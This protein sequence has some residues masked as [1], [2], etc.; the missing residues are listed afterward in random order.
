MTV[1]RPA[2]K[3]GFTLIEL[4]VV[5][6]IIAVLIGLLLPA[7]QRVRAVAQLT[8]CQNNLHQLGLACQSYHDANQTLPINGSVSFYTLILDYVEEGAQ[9]A[10]LASGGAPTQVNTFLCP[11]KGRNGPLCDYV[12]FAPYTADNYSSSGTG[13]V[14]SGQTIKAT[15]Q[16]T[17]SFYASYIGGTYPLYT[18]TWTQTETEKL[19]R[20]A[21]G[22]DQ[23]VRLTD[24]SDGTSTTALLTEKYVPQSQYRSGAWSLGD[25]PWNNP[26]APVYTLNF[27][28]YTTPT[29]PTYSGGPSFTPYLWVYP[30]GQSVVAFYSY[31]DYYPVATTIS[32]TKTST[33][34]K[35]PPDTNSAL[36]GYTTGYT[37]ITSDRN[38]YN[39]YQADYYVG[40]SHPGCATPVAFCDGSVRI[41]KSAWGNGANMDVNMAGINDGQVIVA[42]YDF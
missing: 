35:R 12:A 32:S 25:Q 28:S 5:I 8:N 29:T 1:L 34:T 42:G 7:V 6:A 24:I 2:P 38:S 10:V 18:S 16:N 14:N 41:V 22:D 36:Y 21:M 37:Y 17:P 19:Y 27:K 3:R 15:A 31:A 11:G 33:N 9:T 26:G 4:L 23:G 39:S 13:L 20:T 40:S 30:P